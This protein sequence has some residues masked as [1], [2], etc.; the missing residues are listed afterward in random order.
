MT[1]AVS[2]GASSSTASSRRGLRV[3]L[4]VLQVALALF[5]IMVGDPHGLAPFDEVAQQVDLDATRAA[6]RSAF[7]SATPRSRVDWD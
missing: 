6:A 1:S 2:P 3:T 7:S 4:W 5:F